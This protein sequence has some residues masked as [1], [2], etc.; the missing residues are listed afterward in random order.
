MSEKL[1][2]RAEVP[3]ELTWDISL[4]Y[5][6]EDAL[7]AD[8]KKMDQ[9]VSQM[10]AYKGK[11]MSAQA[12]CD[13]LKAEEE[14]LILGDHLMNYT[15][16]AVEV[17]YYN[18]HNMELSNKVAATLAGYKSR[19]S[20]LESE[21][22]QA[23]EEV[24]KE[25]I[26]MAGGMANYLKEILR[27]KPH[28][29]APEAERVLAAYSD[30]LDLPYDIY[31]QAKLADMKFDPFVVDGKEYPLGYSLFEDDYEYLDDTAVRRAAFD[32]F[33][34]KLAEY[35][36]VTAAAY[37]TCVRKEKI[38]ADLRG[39]DSVFDY[40]LFSHHV[41]REMYDRQIDLIME[42]L[43]PHMQKYAKLIQ[44][45]HGL[46]K[47]TIAD[48][49]IS[50]DPDYCPKVSIAQ[51]KDL[52][53]KGLAIL[54]DDYVEMI[55]EAFDKRWIDF[56]GNQGK[57]TG[58]FCSSPYKKD[59]FILLSWNE[60]MSDVMTLAHELGHA[61]HFR[62]CQREQSI[63]DTD[64]SMYFV[65][66]PSTM[67]ELIFANYLLKTNDDPRFRRWVLSA[68]I[69]NTYYHNFVTHLLEAAH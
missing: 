18:N 8:V 64:V 55:E 24:L 63:A 60:R 56:A 68:M 22:V 29:L 48:L 7:W 39:F 49:K 17:D 31:N 16:L 69:S 19:L 38:D 53:K 10:E 12:I 44:K 3:V 52:L 2:M 5:E 57:C 33:S 23:S 11:L 4:I 30:V 13:C 27:G 9:L 61:G 25:A 20:F 32:A 14:Y 67:N 54:G 26:A 47:M 34:A 51:A 45:I 40:L 46:D 1:L 62:M 35:E 50:I 42:Y 15:E 21:I 41:S 37:N 59:S 58:G 66:A 6:N 36:N 43:A 65:E 28:Q